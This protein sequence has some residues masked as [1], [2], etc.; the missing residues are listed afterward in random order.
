[1][2]S[3][4]TCADIAESPMKIPFPSLPMYQARWIPVLFTPVT[5]GEDVLFVG[6]SCPLDAEEEVKR[7]IK[8]FEHLEGM[9]VAKGKSYS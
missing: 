1:M 8:L 9:R 5:C 3:T 2:R 6:I 4:T 7:V